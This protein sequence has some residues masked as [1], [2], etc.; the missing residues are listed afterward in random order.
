MNAKQINSLIFKLMIL[1]FLAGTVQ[2]AFSQR[3]RIDP[4]KRN[5]NKKPQ[6][7]KVERKEKNNR[8][9]HK[10]FSTEKQR[11]KKNNQDQ[12]FSRRRDGNSKKKFRNKNGNYKNHKKSY[13]RQKHYKK[14]WRGSTNPYSYKSP[15]WYKKNYRKPSW[16]NFHHRN[17]HYPRIGSWVNMLPR[18]FISFRINDYRYFY[19]RGVYYEYDPV[20]NVYIVIRKPDIRATYTSLKWDRITLLDGSVIEG[21]YLHGDSEVV[22]FEVGN[23]ELEI[24]QSEIKLI[25]RLM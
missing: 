13:E 15:K 12:S 18:G 3:V 24:P 19:Y 10:K 23:A 1:M 25:V 5:G 20:F 16:M 21:V 4:G 17:Y 9:E 8:R 22:V 11:R 14:P 2:D 6:V 7:Q